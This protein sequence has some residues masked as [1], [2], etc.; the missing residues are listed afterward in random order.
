MT[1]AKICDCLRKMC[2]LD[3]LMFVSQQTHISSRVKTR[4]EVLMVTFHFTD[5]AGGFDQ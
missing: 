3:L 5:E 4:T 1:G 2:E